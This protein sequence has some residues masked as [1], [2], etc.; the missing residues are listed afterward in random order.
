MQ[1]GLQL[2]TLRDLDESLTATIDRLVD[3]PYDGVQFAG[4]DGA[5]PTAV[6][7]ALGDAGLDDAGAHVRADEIEDD[8]EDLLAAYD[9]LGCDQFVVP[10]YDTTAFETEE[11]ARTAGERLAG[12][13]DRLSADGASLHYHNHTFEFTDLGDGTAFDAFTDAAA[14]VGVEIDT[15]LANHAGVDPVDLFDRYGDR[16]DLVHLT[17]S[18]PGSSGSKH[19]DLGE[20]TV[21]VEA[22]VDAAADC[23]TEW[24]IFEHGQTDH[25]IAS[26]EHA[27][28]VLRPLV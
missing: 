14:G 17:D 12:L 13:S 28:E 5:D 18:R 27:A 2:Y 23:G 1:L 24:I 8:Y 10:T 20:G 22:C 11:G 26:V 21:D 16:V 25:P 19:V 3:G 7:A 9:V 6:A 15:G 4:L